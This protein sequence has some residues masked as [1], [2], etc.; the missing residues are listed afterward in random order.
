MSFA[1]L[2]GFQ[3]V[4]ELQILG[5]WKSPHT[6]TINI[7]TDFGTS[8]S[9]VVT[10][11]VLTQPTIYQF[12][13]KMKVQKCESMQIQITESQSGTYGEG[14]SLSSLAFRVGVKKGL[15]KLPAGASY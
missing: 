2:E 10:I 14:L 1:G 5:T 11:P 15:N 9:Q 6:L 4:W 3:R 7:Y 12:R 8:P 13:I